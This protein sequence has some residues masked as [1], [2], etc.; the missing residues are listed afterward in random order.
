MRIAIFT[1]VLASVGLFTPPAAN[2]V[3]P[4]SIDVRVGPTQ[5]GQYELLR[6]PRG[7]KYTGYLS[8]RDMIGHQVDVALPVPPSGHDMAR[9]H[10]QWFDITF[11]VN[12]NMR[13]RRC[14]T[15]VIVEREGRTWFEQKSSIALPSS[16]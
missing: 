11:S 15:T 2:N 5:S 9:K 10:T 13:D 6:A 16:S 8:V 4:L 12:M 14:D 1:A 7:A 3:Q